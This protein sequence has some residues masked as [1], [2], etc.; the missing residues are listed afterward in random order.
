MN[1]GFQ[2]AVATFMTPGPKCVYCSQYHHTSIWSQS[3]CS[4]LYHKSNC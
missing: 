4:E 1:T 2:S 3:F